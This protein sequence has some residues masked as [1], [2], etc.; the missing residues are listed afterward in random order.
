MSKE[1]SFPLYGGD[2]EA[3]TRISGGCARKKLCWIEKLSLKLEFYGL[4]IMNL[5]SEIGH[6]FFQNGASNTAAH[7]FVCSLWK[8]VLV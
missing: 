8:L 3:P 5:L 4:L 6:S 7:F 1:P 2:F